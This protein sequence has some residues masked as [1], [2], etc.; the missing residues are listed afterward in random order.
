MSRVPYAIVVL[1]VVGIAIL[2]RVRPAA[3]GSPSR[4]WLPIAAFIAGPSVAFL[5]FFAHVIF[6]SGAYITFEE[7]TQM[8][9]SL[10]ILGLFGGTI[11]AIGLWI[12]DRFPLPR[13]R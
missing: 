11:G 3:A 12:G 4:I 5:Y 2:R 1:L 9:S 7:Y 8:F 13:I 6:D 10:M